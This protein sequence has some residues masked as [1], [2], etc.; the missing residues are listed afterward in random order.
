MP[1]QERSQD[2]VAETGFLADD[3]A[4]LIDGNRQDSSR[5]G[6]HRG[7]VGPLPGEHADLAQELGR[8]VGGVAVAPLIAYYASA[9]P[10]ALWEAGGATALFIAG[11]G[12]AGYATR[13]DLTALARA[14][15]WALVALIVFG[16]V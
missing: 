4:H 8:A 1:E 10:Q 6:C 16:I 12:A 3:D 9:D 5:R 13:R 14:C 2:E 11:F 15:S 7:Q